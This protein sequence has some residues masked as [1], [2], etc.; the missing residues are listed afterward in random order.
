M[1]RNLRWL[2]LGLLL[3]SAAV[4]YWV[5]DPRETA[6]MPEDV[7][8]EIVE[9]LELKYV[10]EVK[11]LEQDKEALQRITDGWGEKYADQVRLTQK[12]R[13]EAQTKPAKIYVKGDTVHEPGQIVEVEGDCVISDASMDGTCAGQIFSLGGKKA[14]RV[15][16]TGRAVFNVG[17]TEVEIDS[18]EPRLAE[19]LEWSQETARRPLN[20]LLTARIGLNSA[21]GVS[22]GASL[23]GAQK[24]RGWWLQADYDFNPDSYSSF[25]PQ[26]ESYT[27]VAADRWRVSAG[28]A[29]RFGK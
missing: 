4:A 16:W 22:V 21:P 11:R 23:Y 3:A 20:R 9:A 28:V 7:R 17:D 14:A 27:S 29:W 24:R 12:W 8:D 25:I 18:G 2:I 13:T 15:Y 1:K 19:T 5:I 10:K 26:Q 6:E